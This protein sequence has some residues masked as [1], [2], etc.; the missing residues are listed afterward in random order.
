MEELHEKLRVFKDVKEAIG[1]ASLR[2][3]RPEVRGG[4]ASSYILHSN[5]PNAS[6][7]TMSFV[8]LGV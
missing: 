4:I 1:S 6:G 5:V 3:T 2:R 8:A 7:L